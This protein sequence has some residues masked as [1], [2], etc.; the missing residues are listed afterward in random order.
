M[1]VDVS[2]DRVF[3]DATAPLSC[4]G[5]SSLFTPYIK[6]NVF[7]DLFGRSFSFIITVLKRICDT[8]DTAD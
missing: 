2:A 8:A 6:Q 1:N 7:L 4:T 5:I 3:D